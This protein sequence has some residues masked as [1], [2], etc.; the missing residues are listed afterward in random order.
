MPRVRQNCRRVRRK[1]RPT[2]PRIADVLE[3]E[4]RDGQVVD[5]DP[6]P[7]QEGDVRRHG[8]DAP[9]HD[10]A[11]S[12][13]CSAITDP[14][15]RRRGR[16]TSEEAPATSSTASPTSRQRLP[17][18]A[19]HASPR[20][21]R[22]PTAAAAT[23]WA[24]IPVTSRLPN[25]EQDAARPPAS[26]TTPAKPTRL[27]AVSAD[28]VWSRV[29]STVAVRIGGDDDRDRH[30]DRGDEHRRADRRLRVEPDDPERR[31]VHVTE[32]ERAQ[33]HR[34]G[35]VRGAE[36]ARR[37]AQ[38]AAEQAPWAGREP[39]ARARAREVGRR[40]RGRRL[41]PGRRRLRSAGPGGGVL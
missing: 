20:L 38:A 35:L 1:P 19:A 15:Q 8:D 13:R 10:D 2:A 40:R 37:G 11:R 34:A 33:R 7:G 21:S 14:G 41:P 5:A 27:E 12:A 17:W 31:V 4:H 16:A 39:A 3:H 24:T 18:V 9:G 6:E 26:R 30:R 28:P 23:T 25:D 22:R 32:P 29:T 36:H